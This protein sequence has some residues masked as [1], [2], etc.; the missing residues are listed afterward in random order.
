MPNIAAEALLLSHFTRSSEAFLGFCEYLKAEED[1]TSSAHQMLYECLSKLYLEEKVDKVSKI[2]LISAAKSLGFGNFQAATRNYETIDGILKQNVESQEIGGV[3]TEVKRQS[4]RR[5]YTAA[6]ED[7]RNYVTATND[8]ASSIIGNVEDKIFA[9][10][11]RSERQGR[12]FVKLGQVAMPIM[13]ELAENPGHIGLDIG[14]PQFQAR[15]GEI[16]NASLTFIVATRKAGKSQLGLSRALYVAHKLGIPSLYLD[17]EMDQTRQS[18][19]LMGMMAQIPYNVLKTGYWSLDEKQLR[20][21][22]IPDDE[23]PKILEYGRRM[24]D[25]VLLDKLNRLPLTYRSISGMGMREVLPMI[26]RW[27]L[28]EAKP[29]PSSK[30]PQCLIVYDY[31]KLATVDELKMGG[32]NLQEYQIHGLNVAALHDF[33]NEYNVP[34]LAFGQ[35]NRAGQVAGAKRIEENVD[36]VSFYSRKDEEERAIDGNGSHYI[37]IE[38]SRDGI[39]SSVGHINLNTDLSHGHFEELGYSAIDFT[40]EKKR[41]AEEDKKRKQN[42]HDDC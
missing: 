3:F 2:K 37:K 5:G 11:N 24:R 28:T 36:S 34:I 12:T 40:D 41:R 18:I 30:F 4:L 32:Q 42:D 20:R 1:F 21:L 6:F 23:V 22:D 16:A 14:L 35:T 26:R 31:I 27:L 9:V 25:P 39:D 33:A 19:R 13:E 15:I 17:S 10:G 38:C 8:P 29:D 7:A